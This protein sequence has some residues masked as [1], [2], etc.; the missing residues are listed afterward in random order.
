MEFTPATR[1]L[2]NNQGLVKS[3]TWMEGTTAILLNKKNS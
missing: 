1:N 2:V 3:Q